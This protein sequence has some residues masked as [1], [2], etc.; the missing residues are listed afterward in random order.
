[1]GSKRRSQKPKAYYWIISL[2]TIMVL[3]GL[4]MITSASHIIAIFKHKDALY[5]FERQTLY[6]IVGAFL[7]WMT[8][9]ID[10]RKLRA[11][12]WPIVAVTTLLLV[13]LFIPQVGHTSGGASRWIPLYIINLQ[14]SEIAKLAAI[15][16]TV[17]LLTEQDGS[18]FELINFLPFIVVLVIVGLILAEPDLGTAVLIVVSIFIVLFI[19]GIKLRFLTLFSS[20][21]LSATMGLVLLEPYRFRRLIAFLNPQKYA[22][23]GGFQITQSLIAM[24]SG[25]ITGV[26]LAMSKQKFFFLPAAHTDFI[27]AII[28]EELGWLGVIGTVIAFALLAIVGF[29][30]AYN[31]SDNY[32]KLLAVGLTV[33]LTFQAMVN[34]GAVVGI[35]PITG[36]PL[37]LISFGGS[38]LLVTMTSLGIITS[39]SS[40]STRR[41]RRR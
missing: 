33:L 1:M 40:H 11:L 34:M 13:V 14:P 7:F 2:T 41:R 32:G 35:M 9:R 27:L 26:G 30:I 5:F 29:S 28:G 22:K 18:D 37:P 6:A 39:I 4:I 36:V 19:R 3:F 20:F 25:G 12:T 38:S 10:Y 17:Y 15:M 23:E 8:A 24:G 31:A 21:G 16:L